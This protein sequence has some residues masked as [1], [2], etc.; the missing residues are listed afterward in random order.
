MEQLRKFYVM[1]GALFLTCAAT[2]VVIWHYPAREEQAFSPAYNE[3]A[4]RLSHQIKLQMHDRNYPEAEKLIRKYTGLYPEDLTISKFLGRIYYETGRRDRAL[5]LF[6]ALQVY[7][8]EDPVLHNNIGVLLLQRHR[9]EQA[10]RELNHAHRISGGA[11][12]TAL[13]LARAYELTGHREAAVE[14]S[15]RYRKRN[16]KTVKVPL[17][18]ILFDR[19]TK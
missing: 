4:I 2:G 14:L 1:L 18:A 3:S 8:P 6:R 9:F 12:Y 15:L 17:G 16:G 10:L 19:V 11:D 13:N 7:F 5:E